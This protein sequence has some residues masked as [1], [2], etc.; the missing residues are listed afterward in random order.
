MTHAGSSTWRLTLRQ[1]LSRL[2][3]V[4]SG[5]PGSGSRSGCEVKDR[6]SLPRSDTWAR[7]EKR[8]TIPEGFDHT[9]DS[10]HDPFIHPAI[11]GG[12]IERCISY[13]DPAQAAVPCLAPELSSGTA[14]LL[15]IL[16]ST[17]P[18]RLIRSSEKSCPKLL[19][20][21]AED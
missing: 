20:K 12:R 5:R 19:T 2:K 9:T 6:H 1:L 14:L 4:P 21:R 17:H 15:V 10:H 7:T 16:S 13:D 18:R 3:P 8:L 11:G